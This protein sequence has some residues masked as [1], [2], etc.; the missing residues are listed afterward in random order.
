MATI[1]SRE[2]GTM[3]LGTAIRRWK[4]NWMRAHELDALDRE[5][6]DA[7]ARDIGVPAEML[8]ISQ[9]MVCSA[10]VQGAPFAS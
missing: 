9:V 3:D 8:P 7:L 6:R 2:E 10:R 1:I 4:S 5:Q